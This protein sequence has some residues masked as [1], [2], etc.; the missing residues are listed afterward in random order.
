MG[1]DIDVCTFSIHNG[2][3][4]RRSVKSELYLSYNWSDLSQICP[5]HFLTGTDG[6]C[7]ED[8][9]CEHIH[10]WYF[11]DDCHAR[12]G[13]DILVRAK[14]AL[15]LLAKFGVVPGTPDLTNSNWGYGVRETAEI[16]EVLGMRKTVRLPPKE[17]VAIF[18]YHVKRFLDEA[19]KYP[20][21]FFI[22]DHNDDSDLILPDGTFVPLAS[23]VCSDEDNEPEHIQL[24]PVTYFRHPFKGNFRV[25]NFKTAM[26][27]YGLV[28]AQGSPMADSWY[29]LA[30]QMPDAPGK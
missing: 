28:S 8:S 14:A 16:C 27:V 11:K 12:R 15:E 22:G 21:C 2:K 29:E 1:F 13:D 26:E 6:R 4:V 10:L 25:D 30:M 9:D 5:K 23:D 19:V 17:R 3:A 20:Q 18:A 24:G 7:P